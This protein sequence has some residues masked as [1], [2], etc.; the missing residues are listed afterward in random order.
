MLMLMNCSPWE[1]S[2]VSQFGYVGVRRDNIDDGDVDSVLDNV[3]DNV[4][5]NVLDNVMDIVQ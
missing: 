3:V 5:D 4:M 1:P 2:L